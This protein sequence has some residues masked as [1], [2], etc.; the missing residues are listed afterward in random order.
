M[1]TNDQMS[2]EE[3]TFFR[4]LEERLSSPTRLESRDSLAE[5]LN[6]AT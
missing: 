2:G 3:E 5:L 4:V 6:T 1:T